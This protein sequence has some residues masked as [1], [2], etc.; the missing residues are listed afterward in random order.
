MAT[1]CIRCSESNKVC[2]ISDGSTRCKECIRSCRRCIDSEPSFSDAEWHRLLAAQ[3]EIRG[4]ESHVQNEIES[5]QDKLNELFARS[6]RFRKQENLLQQ[7]AGDFISREIKTIEELEVLEKQEEE[8]RARIAAEERKA[9]PLPAAH[10]HWKEASQYDV[11]AKPLLSSGA[12]Q[13]VGTLLALVVVKYTSR[14]FAGI[15]TLLLACVGCASMLG[16]LSD[17]N[18]AQYGGYI[19]MYQFPICVVFI[20]TFLTA[21]VAGTTKKFYQLGYAVG[22][23]IGPQ[24]YPETDAPDYY[25]AEYTM[26]TFFIFSALL[27]GSCGG[28]HQ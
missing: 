7:R 25:P 6:R 26:L 20:I 5:L 21:G 16:I 23:I 10:Y 4:K 2:I 13:V 17:N 3:K 22:N 8:E 1:R 14:T 12:T 18:S 11:P 24:T 27:I 9:K 15:A 28:V 19:L